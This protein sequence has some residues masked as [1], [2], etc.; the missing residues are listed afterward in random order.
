M[1]LN[2]NNGHCSK[3][4]A[5]FNEATKNIDNFGLLEIILVHWADDQ[6]LESIIEAIENLKAENN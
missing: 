3:V 5:K 1:V 6:D 2:T 4:I